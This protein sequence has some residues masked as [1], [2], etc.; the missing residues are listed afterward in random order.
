MKLT[1]HRETAFRVSTP[2]GHVVL[3]GPGET[4]EVPE[5]LADACVQAGLSPTTATAKGSRASAKE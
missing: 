1:N 2:A 5:A 4:R 3:F